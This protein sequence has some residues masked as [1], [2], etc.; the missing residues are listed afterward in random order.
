[1]EHPMG[2][3]E[4]INLASNFV[5]IGVFCLVVVILPATSA[6]RWMVER[7]KRSRV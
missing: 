7:L 4:F 5:V 1:M 2:V 6:L 3:L